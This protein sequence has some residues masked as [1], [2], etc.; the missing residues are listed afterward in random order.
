MPLFLRLQMYSSPTN[1]QRVI[2]RDESACGLEK[3]QWKCLTPQERFGGNE[4]IVMVNLLENHSSTTR[5]CERRRVT[6]TAVG[7]LYRLHVITL[8]RF[9]SILYRSAHD[10]YS[11][12]LYFCSGSMG[13]S[14]STSTSGH[15]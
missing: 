8:P 4:G 7:T 6:H 13:V 15:E 11:P 10:T 3:E 12:I 9:R 5:E 2:S 14:F 1:F